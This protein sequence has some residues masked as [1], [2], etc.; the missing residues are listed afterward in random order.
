VPGGG[1]EGSSRPTARDPLLASL[2][3]RLGA[4]EHGA[5]HNSA[6][7]AAIVHLSPDVKKWVIPFA[8][9][10]LHHRIGSGSFGQVSC[11]SCTWRC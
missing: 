3:G 1:G 5:A 11:E 7:P 10:D 9:L 8:A 2:L 4:A 6:D